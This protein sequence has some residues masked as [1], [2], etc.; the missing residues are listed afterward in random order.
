MISKV[1]FK[2]SHVYDEVLHNLNKEKKLLERK[3]V[4]R[5]IK[6]FEKIWDKKEKKTLS[7]LSRITGLKWKEKTV[8]CYVVSYSIPFSDPM[9]VPVYRGIDQFIDTLVHEMIHQLFIQGD[10]ME[11]ARKSWN[12][13]FKKYENESFKVKTHIPLHALHKHIYL[14]YFDKKRLDNDYNRIRRLPDYK[15]SW[16]IVN[17]E[18]YDKIIKKFKSRVI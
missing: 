4:Y 16:D 2:Y 3:E 15:R 10:N 18:C 9:T 6:K 17:E 12:Y 8:N 1:V 13:F 7:E 14:K 5:F 11:R